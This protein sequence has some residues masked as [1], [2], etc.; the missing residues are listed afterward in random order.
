MPGPENFAT[1]ARNPRLANGIQYQLGDKTKPGEQANR[2]RAGEDIGAIRDI[3]PPT[4]SLE[5]N[6]RIDLR[7]STLPPVR[8]PC[9]CTRHPHKTSKTRSSASSGR[10]SCIAS[11]PSGALGAGPRGNPCGEPACS[12]PPVARP[13]ARRAGFRGW[14]CRATRDASLRYPMTSRGLHQG[15]SHGMRSA[16]SAAGCRCAWKRGE[17]RLR[18]FFSA[19]RTWV[20]ARY[21][22]RSC[23]A[24]GSEREAVSLIKSRIIGCADLGQS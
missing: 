17:E 2:Q 22:K 15:A 8:Q 1:R 16:G 6:P 3:F 18:C 23:I 13:S 24:D 21:A 5:A 11:E 12:P 14:S 9:C 10:Q 19:G 20:L 4:T 7:I